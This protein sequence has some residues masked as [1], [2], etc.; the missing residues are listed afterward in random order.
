MYCIYRDNLCIS[1]KL[2]IGDKETKIREE[3][4]ELSFNF[5][6]NHK[7]RILCKKTCIT[8]L[9]IIFKQV[10]LGEKLRLF[11]TIFFFSKFGD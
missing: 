11:Q 4:Y 2:K 6:E 1:L 9:F 7:I 3:A 5:F 10:S 8:I